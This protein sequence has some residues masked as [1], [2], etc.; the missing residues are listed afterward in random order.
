MTIKRQKKRA[1]DVIFY[2]SMLAWPLL[3][4]FIMWFLVNVNSI[5]LAFK[6]YDVDAF[7]YE[8]VG[9]TNFQRVLT[10]LFN[11]GL[12][13][14]A[15]KNSI[16][17][18]LLGLLTMPL[19][20]LLSFYLYKKSFGHKFF[21]VVLNVPSF[22]SAVVFT[23]IFKYLA[24]RAFPEVVKSITG[25][26][27]LGLLVGDFAFTAI[28]I[29][30]MYFSLCGNIL[31]YLGAMNGI[32]EGLF[33]AATLDGATMGKEFIHIVLPC[34]WPT[35]S[36]ILIVGTAGILTSDPGLYLIYAGAAPTEYY[37]FGYYMFKGVKE[38]SP[39]IGYPYYSAFGLLLTAIAIPMVFGF[40]KLL[41]KIDPMRD[42]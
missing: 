16:W 4:F 13:F 36:T 31:L 40:K 29:K 35:I 38:A 33:E 30:N 9:L 1:S 17:H 19:G 25:E 23:I 18:Y 26:D 41:E 24:D 14:I 6:Q 21:K 10:D 32:D 7:T 37:T 39:I 22:I 42:V 5:L 12:F 20:I 2:L 28:L 8:F 3:Q 27:T 11:D 34:I 15:L